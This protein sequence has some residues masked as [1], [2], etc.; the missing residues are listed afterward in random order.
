M[1]AIGPALARALQG[2]VTALV[3]YV[4]DSVT[5]HFAFTGAEPPP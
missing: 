5:A 3:N 1:G 4:G 2:G